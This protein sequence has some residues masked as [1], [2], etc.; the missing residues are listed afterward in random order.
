MKKYKSIIIFLIKFFVTYFLLVTIYNSYLQHSQEKE[1]V[2]KTASITT[3]VADQTVKVLTFFGY[4]VEAIQHDKE[5]SVKLVIEGEYTARVIE[6]CNSISLIIL[7]ISF[8]IAFSGSFKATF[9]FAIF[10]SIF[11]YVVNVLRIAFLTVMIYKF[12]E[13]LGILHDLVFPAIIYGA[14]FLLWVVWVNKFS[15]LKK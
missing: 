13:Q 11:I 12:P 5:V 6:G 1:G 10:G 15:N 14:I 8:I 3:L 4:N 7:F 2:Y 9:L